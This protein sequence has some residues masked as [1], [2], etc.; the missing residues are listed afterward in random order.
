M[1]K[2]QPVYES[3]PG[4][5]TDITS[6][7]SLDDL[8]ANAIAYIQRISE[9]VGRPVEIISVGPDRAQTIFC[10]ESLSVA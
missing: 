2:V 4:W 5:Q 9:L 6:A 7:R 8:P 3:L 1:R 10:N